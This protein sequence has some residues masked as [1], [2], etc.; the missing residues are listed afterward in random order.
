MSALTGHLLSYAQTFASN[1]YRRPLAWAALTMPGDQ[2]ERKRM[3]LLTVRD[4]EIGQVL[5]YEH[6]ESGVMIDPLPACTG[7]TPS[8]AE[9]RNQSEL[10]ALLFS[11]PVLTKHSR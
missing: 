2:G 9:F 4:H 1:K 8:G 10:L 6:A 7:R 3:D 11:E 5:R